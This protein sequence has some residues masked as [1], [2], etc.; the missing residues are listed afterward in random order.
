[1]SVTAGLVANRLPT[2]LANIAIDYL[3]RSG[4]AFNMAYNGQYEDCKRAIDDWS[5][6]AMNYMA[7]G[8]CE[9]GHLA[10][11]ELV[12]NN[13]TLNWRGVLYYACRN[14]NDDLTC[15]NMAIANGANE[16]NDGLDGASQV[17][18]LAIAQMMIAHGASD[19]N[20]SLIFACENGRSLDVVK[21]LI[22]KGATNLDRGLSNACYAG[23]REIVKFLI[24]RGVI[25]DCGRSPEAHLSN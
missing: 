22:D 15:V 1:M 2:C 10:I 19:L 12:A 16:W 25:C 11:A 13:K 18:N 23:H 20:T 4:F 5:E 17:G 7:Y 3:G 24:S 9:G 21:L 8:A 14:I 6:I